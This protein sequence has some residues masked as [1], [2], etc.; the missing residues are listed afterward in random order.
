MS[1]QTKQLLYLH[2][3]VV[4]GGTGAPGRRWGWEWSGVI[5]GAGGGVSV[6]VGLGRVGV[7]RRRG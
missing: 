2:V 7:R 6:R 3:L 5:I 4:S 1:R